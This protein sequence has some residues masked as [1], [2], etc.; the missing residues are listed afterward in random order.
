MRV[1]TFLGIHLETVLIENMREKLEGSYG[2]FWAKFWCKNL[3]KSNG[4]YKQYSPIFH[5]NRLLS[6]SSD[7][8]VLNW[9]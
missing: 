1:K 4:E 7:E 3:H 6:F 5:E 8:E 2:T 9:N